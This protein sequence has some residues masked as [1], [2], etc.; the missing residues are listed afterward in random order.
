MIEKKVMCK[1]KM[2]FIILAINVIMNIAYS[3]RL[4]ILNGLRFGDYL[5]IWRENICTIQGL[6]IIEIIKND[7]TING[8]SMPP[9][10]ST[11]PYARILATLIH[12]GFLDKESVVIYG[13][14]LY[15]GTIIVAFIILYKTVKRYIHFDLSC[16]KVLMCLLFLSSWYLGEGILSGNNGLFFSMLLIIA[17]CIVDDHEVTAGILLAFAM[18][19]PQLAGLFY[20]SLLIKK[21]Y[22]TIFT[23]FIILIASWAIYLVAVGGNPFTQMIDMLAQSKEKTGDFLW[24]GIFD[25]LVDLG[26]S[27]T[28]VIVCG[29]LLG[30]CATGVLSVW[31]IKTKNLDCNLIYYS[32][33]AL[34]STVWCY[35]SPSD[36]VILILPTILCL[37]VIEQKEISKVQWMLIITYIFIL[38]GKVFC[39]LFR[40]L[41]GYD[42]LIGLSIDAYARVVVF[43]VMLMLLEHLGKKGVGFVRG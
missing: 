40:R 34:F 41:W 11:M 25:F 10:S 3:V 37:F 7:L 28:I 36:L 24:F 9:S 32:I 8:I 5:W 35:K 17:V 26:V 14:T 2:T 29:M 12:P 13:F 22:K 30:I 42:W 4:F 6:D 16:F 21:K 20:I 27:G 23:S 38:N 15:A 19:K 18:I 31:I 43:I 33:P 39:G 1:K